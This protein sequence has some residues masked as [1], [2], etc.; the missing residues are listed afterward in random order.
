M[1]IGK[2]LVIGANVHLNVGLELKFKNDNV[3]HHKMEAKNAKDKLFKL[4]HVK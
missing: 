2:Q 1:G 4:D 3:F